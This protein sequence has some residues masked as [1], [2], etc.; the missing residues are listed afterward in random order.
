MT[1]DKYF[2][3]REEKPCCICGRVFK[4]RDRKQETCGARSCVNKV[5]KRKAKET[6]RL[7]YCKQ[8]RRKITG[9]GREF[10]SRTCYK[11]WMLAESRRKNP[12]K[13]TSCQNT[14]CRKPLD[15]IDTTASGARRYRFDKK[16]CDEK[17]KGGHYTELYST[18]EWKS[19]L[20]VWRENGKPAKDGKKLEGN[21]NVVQD[22]LSIFG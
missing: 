16:Y 3:Y 13:Y 11:D 1:T 20:K 10:C 7:V 8:C 4:P 15:H 22:C 21:L 18:G 6:K 9:E 5:C 2:E 12:P 17:C 14:K 19:N